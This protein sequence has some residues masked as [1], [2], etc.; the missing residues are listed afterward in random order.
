MPVPD[1]ATQRRT[2]LTLA[3]A[4][5]LL[6]GLLFFEVLAP[7]LIGSGPAF[8]AGLAWGVVAVAGLMIVLSMQFRRSREWPPAVRARVGVGL[9]QMSVGFGVIAL[10]VVASRSFHPPWVSIVGFLGGMAIIM[11]STLGIPA[12]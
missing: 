8:L 10:G 2:R 11:L 4:L 9:A 6:A 1:E 5:F 7:G 12:R 3:L